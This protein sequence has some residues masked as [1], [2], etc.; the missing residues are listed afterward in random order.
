MDWTESICDPNTPRKDF[1]TRLTPATVAEIDAFRKENRW[2]LPFLCATRSLFLET[3]ARFLL[4][5]L[6]SG[7][8]GVF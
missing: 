2:K 6:K 1:H 4:A 7:P 8:I 3:A 5:T